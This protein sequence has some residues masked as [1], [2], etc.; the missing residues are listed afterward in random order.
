MTG[1]V[2][3]LT[4]VVAAMAG[5]ETLQAARPKLAVLYNFRTTNHVGAS[6]KAALMP[7]PLSALTIPAWRSNSF[8]PL[9]T[10]AIGSK[11]IC[12]RFQ[13]PRTALSRSAACIA[14]PMANFSVS[15]VPAARS[16]G[17]RPT[18]SSSECLRRLV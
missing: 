8:R 5:A 14:N 11:R 3:G 17:G 1:W 6:P 18:S 16:K 4:V 10:V 13:G 12:I 15:P 7:L 9:Q 2:T